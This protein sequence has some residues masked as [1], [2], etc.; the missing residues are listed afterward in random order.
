MYD[1][2]RHLLKKFLLIAGYS[3]FGKQIFFHSFDRH[4]WYENWRRIFFP[5]ILW[6]PNIPVLLVPW[7]C[8]LFCFASLQTLLRNH[9]LSLITFPQHKTLDSHMQ[10]LFP[11]YISSIR[12]L[13]RLYLL[14]EAFYSTYFK[15]GSQ[16]NISIN[17]SLLCRCE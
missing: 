3:V 15:G 5:C 14:M 9:N 7:Q 6:I 4:Q 12:Q 2:Y 17:M 16:D 10:S 13:S 11:F 8:C 1:S